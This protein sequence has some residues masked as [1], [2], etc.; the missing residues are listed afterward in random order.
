LLVLGPARD[1]RLAREP[2]LRAPELDN[3]YRTTASV[4]VHHEG[5]FAYFLSY[6]NLFPV[7]TTLTAPPK[8]ESGADWVIARH[9]ESLVQDLARG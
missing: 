2:C 6:K 3:E 8:G 7:A 4:G 1:L 9:P 5:Q